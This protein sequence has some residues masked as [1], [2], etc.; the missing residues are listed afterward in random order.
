MINT[1]AD[2][3]QTQTDQVLG[4]N[5]PP[6]AG[7]SSSPPAHGVL[8]STRTV[9]SGRRRTGS[10][11]PPLPT[12]HHD[13][14][15]FM[16]PFYENAPH[17]GG[18]LDL[19]PRS[20][21]PD[22]L[23]SRLLDEFDRLALTDQQLRALLR[24]QALYRQVQAGLGTKMSL[25]I[26]QLRV[27]PEKLT[28]EGRARRKR[29]HRALGAA[30]TQQGLN[31]DIALAEVFE[32]LTREQLRRL[33]EAYMADVDA[34]L[35]KLAPVLVAAVSPTYALATDT[36]DGLREVDPDPDPGEFEVAESDF[37]DLALARDQTGAGATVRDLP[38]LQGQ[39]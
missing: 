11:H 27:S 13:R 4:I 15:L 25:I 38:V 23:L 17:R 36:E 32:V 34:R 3:R 9:W 14:D 7:G 12:L 37:F 5:R 31:A 21:A 10:L 18:A 28:S 19:T 33:G 1:L 39:S 8:P 29:L 24:V 2:L 6:R 30:H 26:E 20:F 16:P 22:D 35:Q